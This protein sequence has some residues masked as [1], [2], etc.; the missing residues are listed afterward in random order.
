MDDDWIM[1]ENELPDT[2]IPMR[3]SK[4]RWRLNPPGYGALREVYL[5][6]SGLALTVNEWEIPIDNGKYKNV[7]SCEEYEYLAKNWEFNKDLFVREEIPVY[8]EE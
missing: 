7:F 6:A 1:A 4:Y 2:Y 3:P 5:A 8:K